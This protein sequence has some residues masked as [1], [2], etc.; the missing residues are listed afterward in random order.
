MGALCSSA[1]DGR[2]HNGMVPSFQLPQSLEDKSKEFG[3]AIK[4][5]L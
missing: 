5:G 1:G 3:C 2:A 4:N